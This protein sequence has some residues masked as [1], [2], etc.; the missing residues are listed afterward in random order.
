MIESLVKELDLRKSYL[1]GEEVDTVYF[2]G[3][4]PSLLQESHLKKILEKIFTLFPGKKSEITLEANP[5]DLNQKSLFAWK[6]L[7]IDRLSLGVQSFQEEIL[8]AYN[9]AH[10]AEESK[11]AIQLARK[12]G[13]EKFSFD[14]IYGFPHHNHELWEKDLA[15]ALTLDPGHISAYAL[16]IEPKTAFGNWTQKGNFLPASEDFIAEE[17]EW[18]QEQLSNSGYI[19][20]EIS[21][22]AK[23]GQFAIHNS[24]YWTGEPY[25]GLGPSAH[26]F[27]GENRGYNPSSNPAYVRSIDSGKVPFIPENLDPSERI[28]ERILTGLRTIWGLDLEVLNKKYDCDLFGLQKNKI[29]KFEKSGLLEVKGKIL[30]LTGRG[31]LLA[32]SI[33]TELFV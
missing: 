15:E 1:S 6:S 27:D 16:T 2:G 31:Q 17:F 20:Y 23:P 21:N 9:R 12:A 30:S 28:N 7:G 4:T 8:R 10:T 5:D 11:K 25:L 32:D 24:N 18:L 13:F 22:F 26:S 3:G 29:E 33:A 14:L 19:Q